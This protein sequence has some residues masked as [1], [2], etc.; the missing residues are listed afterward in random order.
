MT[1][2]IPSGVTPI[3]L[4]QVQGTIGVEFVGDNV[5]SEWRDIWGM[6]SYMYTNNPH[7]RYVNPAS[8]GC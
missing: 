6:Q 3:M 8:T 4:Q 1:F 7:L 2:D 5:A